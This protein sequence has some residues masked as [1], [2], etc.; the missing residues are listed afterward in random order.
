MGYSEFMRE[1]KH[2]SP[3]ALLTS[4]GASISGGIVLA[5]GAIYLKLFFKKF[6]FE[7]VMKFKGTGS[8]VS[9]GPLPIGIGF[10]AREFPSKGGAVLTRSERTAERF[11]MQ[12][13]VGPCMMDA[14]EASGGIT[15][16][17]VRLHFGSSG[18]YLQTKAY[19]ELASAS[20]SIP[21]A[22]SMTFTGNVSWYSS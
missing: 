3:V 11:V 2:P 15:G 4:E 8:G 7:Y 12:D 9:V 1:F 13:L 10:G 17:I 5:A 20:L 19:A 16:G 22:S 18:D 14:G 6:D 21:G